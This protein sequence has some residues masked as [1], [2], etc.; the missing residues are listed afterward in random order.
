MKSRFKKFLVKTFF[1]RHKLIFPLRHHGF[2]HG[3]SKNLK[4]SFNKL[5]KIQVTLDCRKITFKIKNTTVRMN[6]KSN[7]YYIYIHF[8]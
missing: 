6:P 4:S 3:N 5:C 1:Q 8:D 2:S 7:K